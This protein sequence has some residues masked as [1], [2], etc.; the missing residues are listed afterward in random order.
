MWSSAVTSNDLGTQDDID[1][2]QRPSTYTVHCTVYEYTPID[3]YFTE[4]RF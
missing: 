4:G 1:S 3:V 2:F